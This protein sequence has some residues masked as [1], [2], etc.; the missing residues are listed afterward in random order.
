MD[1]EVLYSNE[2][3][4]FRKEVSTWLEQNGPKMEIPE[5]LMMGPEHIAEFNAWRERLGKKGW[6]APTWPK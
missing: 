4:E 3:E 5:E 6:L 1:F 2:Q